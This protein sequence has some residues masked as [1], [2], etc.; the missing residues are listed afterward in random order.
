MERAL[1]GEAA[2]DPDPKKFCKTSRRE[3][4]YHSIDGK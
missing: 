2:S 1:Y 4:K 3:I